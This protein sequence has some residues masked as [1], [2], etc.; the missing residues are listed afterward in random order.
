MCDV[1]AH[2]MRI[3]LKLSSWRWCP[4]FANSILRIPPCWTKLLHAKRQD[5]R[6]A[7]NF[8]DLRQ[9]SMS[10]TQVK[11]T[12]YPI[13]AAEMPCISQSPFKTRVRCFQL[14][15][16]RCQKHI[17][18]FFYSFFSLYYTYISYISLS[19][20][21]N[22]VVNLNGSSCKPTQFDFFCVTW[23]MVWVRTFVSRP[24][25]ELQ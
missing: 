3:P 22:N 18:V 1:L 4:K 5:G 19:L 11:W 20:S 24:C 6:P 8:L 25:V 21:R 13:F 7:F 10:Y 2:M 14:L 15:G 17:W 9:V 12:E 16:F 23:K